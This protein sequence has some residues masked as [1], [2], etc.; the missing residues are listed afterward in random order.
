MRVKI[1][2][3][4]LDVNASVALGFGGV[5]LQVELSGHVGTGAKMS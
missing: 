1:G 4:C 2:R 5:M 3:I